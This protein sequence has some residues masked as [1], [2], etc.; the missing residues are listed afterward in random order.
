MKNDTFM[1]KNIL[2]KIF[3]CF[4]TSTSLLSAFFL[5]FP[6]T[7]ATIPIEVTSSELK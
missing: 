7:V 4:L 6:F 1:D 5:F 2:G 3:V